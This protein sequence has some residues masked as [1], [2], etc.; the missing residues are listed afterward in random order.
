MSNGCLWILFFSGR[1]QWNFDLGG[2]VGVCGCL[3]VM[4]VEGRSWLGG[5]C[6]GVFFWYFFC[7]FRLYT[8]PLFCSFW[9]TDVCLV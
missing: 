8:T 3:L 5:V 1:L 7:M 4:G 2:D 6:F 9:M